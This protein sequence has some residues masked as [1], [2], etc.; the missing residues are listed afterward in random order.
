MTHS[1]RAI[2]G[3]LVRRHR[4]GLAAVA[5]TLTVAVTAT[6]LA[7]QAA[8]EFAG[9]G[10]VLL[11]LG[12]CY[13][14]AVFAFGFDTDV[15]GAGSC[16]P[17]RMFTLP[18]RTTALAGW[19]VAFGATLFALAW[20]VA[21]GLIFRPWGYRVPLAWPALLAV[22]QLVWLQA[23]L[24]WPF[25]VPWARVVVAV[26]IGHI[27]AT[28]T[29]YFLRMSDGPVALVFLGIAL[30]LGVIAAYAGVVR[31][32][33]GAVPNWDWVSRIGRLPF[34]RR[35]TVRGAFGSAG[36]AQAWYEWRRHGYILPIL[37][38]A[39][40]PVF[41]LSF[42]VDEA[43]SARYVRE[44]GLLILARDFALPLAVPVFLAGM[45]GT[46]VG[47]HNPWVRDRYGVSSYVVTRPVTTAGLVGAMLRGAFR[48]T[49]GTWAL[50][51][52]MI[53]VAVVVTGTV[54]PL[55]KLRQFLLATRP[56]A[57]IVTA[58]AAI[59]AVLLLLTWKRIVDNLLIGL[60]GREWLV[61]GSV[62][63]GPFV[64]FNVVLFVLWLMVHPEYRDHIWEWVPWCLTCAVGLK[65]L[66]AAVVVWALRR[67]RL[68]ADRTLAAGAGV[69]LVVVAGL[70]TLLVWVL[71]AGVVAAH[72]VVMAVILITPLVRMSAMPLALDWNR[73]R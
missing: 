45:A 59:V 32:R 46:I 68:V 24:W 43:D 19:P 26:L 41:L 5:G 44:F 70:S 54:E 17:S 56:V 49:L 7:P 23:L 53:A 21:A 18:V 12:V 31:A 28:G 55:W 64:F 9:L 15:A 51:A 63:A 62:F 47:K 13:A 65:V 38:A 14:A 35:R 1:A 6:A 48:T 4:R 8:S 69:W 60:T 33:R 3:M 57:E 72:T 10:W 37:V 11:I 25:G 66:A 30:A 67:R 40:L 27:P 36:K 50:A 22:A 42:L 20:L 29:L 58:A 39:V 34:A 73:H 2:G 16:Y 71:P 61:K 52:A